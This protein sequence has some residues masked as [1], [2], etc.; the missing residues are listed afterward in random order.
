MQH[1]GKHPKAFETVRVNIN[2]EIHEFQLEDW[3]HRVSGQYW[4]DSDGNPA[5]LR[6]A[7]RVMQQGLP[8]DNRV[9]YGKI[10][11][12]GHLVHETEILVED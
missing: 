2:G 5:A 10:G 9:V 8:L 3:W 12:F 1:D 7:I 4:M 11:P 6:Y